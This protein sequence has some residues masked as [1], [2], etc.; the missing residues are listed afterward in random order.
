MHTYCVRVIEGTLSLRVRRLQNH[1]LLLL[2]WAHCFTGN[3]ALGR[4]ALL[5][6]P[7]LR[8]RRS[9]RNRRGGPSAHGAGG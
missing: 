6:F 8:F 3:S 1:L 2:R 5:S 4:L 9:S 7:C